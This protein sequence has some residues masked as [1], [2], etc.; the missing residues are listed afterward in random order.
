[1]ILRWGESTD[2]RE[3]NYYQ[4]NIHYIYSRRRKTTINPSPDYPIEILLRTA[5]APLLTQTYP[6]LTPRLTLRCRGPIR[7]TIPSLLRL[8]RPRPPRLRPRS[9]PELTPPP[10]CP[11]E[12]LLPHLPWPLPPLPLPPSPAAPRLSSPR[13]PP[14]QWSCPK[15]SPPAPSPTSSATFAS[16]TCS[17]GESRELRGAKRRAIVSTLY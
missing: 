4:L 16:L 13:P 15:R 10:G 5:P 11:A 2:W 1:M 6:S 14:T 12:P 3:L 7:T 9:E 17:R 8:R